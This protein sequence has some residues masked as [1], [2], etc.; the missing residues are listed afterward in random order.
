MSGSVE[1]CNLSK[2]FARYGQP[3]AGSLK[4]AMRRGFRP[5]RATE[6]YWALRDVSFEVQP[7]EMLGVIGHNGSGKSTLLRMVGGVM[8]SDVGSVTTTGR[9]SGLLEL[10]AGMHPELSGRDNILI[11]GVVAGL[12]RK[13]ITARMDEVIAFAE[14][15][16]FIDSPVRT[17]S[18]GMRLRLGFAVAIHTDP[19]VILIDE[20][21]SVGDLAFQAKCL[22]RIRRHR[23]EGSAIILITHDLTQVENL[24]T[25]VLWLRKG[26]VVGQGKPDVLVGEYRAAM[27][28]DSRHRTPPSMPETITSTGTILRA[29]ENRFGSMEKVIENVCLED[30]FSQC[31]REIATGD[32]LSILIQFSGGGGPAPIVGL[33]IGT[34]DGVNVLD[35]NTEGD[36]IAISSS[37]K[38]SIIRVD[39]DRVDL[40]S[41]SYFINIGLFHSSWEYAYDYHWQAYPLTILGSH[42]PPGKLSPPRT[43][44]LASGDQR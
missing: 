37:G 6:N 28:R 15:E 38:S 34:L 19:G 2:Q 44:T 32:A 11:G 33:S 13:Q 20:V 24:C 29:H 7:G 9:I 4:E 18:M 26:A 27:A 12:T 43:W 36:N 3:R 41:G 14:L 39:L 31:V 42:G 30:Q 23:D 10:N 35:I 21:L 22:D 17:Y 8:R 25:D 5:A 16:E 1:V 40:T